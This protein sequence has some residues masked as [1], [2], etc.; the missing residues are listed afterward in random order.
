MTYSAKGTGKAL[1]CAQEGSFSISHFFIWPFSESYLWRFRV[2]P[3]IVSLWWR[4]QND[5]R[6]D[7]N[8]RSKDDQSEMENEKWKMKSVVL[9]EVLVQ[10]LNHLTIVPFAVL[11]GG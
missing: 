9:A 11:P 6:N 8:G 10:E 4:E 2:T 5:P 7:T 1:H 3:W